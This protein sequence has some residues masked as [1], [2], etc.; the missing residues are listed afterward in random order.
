MKLVSGSVFNPQEAHLR[1]SDQ[2]F[3]RIYSCVAFPTGDIEIPL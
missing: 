3:G 1:K 2:N